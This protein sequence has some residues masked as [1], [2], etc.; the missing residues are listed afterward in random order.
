MPLLVAIAL[1]ASAPLPAHDLR[2]TIRQARAVAHG[3]GER[4]W[5][6]FAHASLPVDLIAADRETLFCAPPLP[7]FAA[8]GR[9]P[10][11]GCTVQAR[12]RRL[13]VDLAGASDLAGRSVIQI[14]LPATLEFTPAEWKLTLIHESFHQYQA[15]LPG[16]RAAVA[17]IGRA[18][19]VGGSGWFLGYAFPYA[20]PRVGAA[21]AAMG[22]AARAFLAARSD[23]ERRIA[24]GD[25]VTA[26]HAARAAAGPQAWQYYE[27]QAGQEGVARWTELTLASG[28]AAAD[29]ALA[30]VAQDRRQGLSTSLDAVDQQ[31]LAVWKR[32]AFYVFGALEAEMLERLHRPWRAAYR[33]HPLALGDQLDRAVAQS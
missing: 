2:A 23:A 20:D 24:V 5:P 12:P 32:S 8:A 13:P 18:L 28:E 31:G 6:G 33:A 15:Q 29:P 11:T 9:D 25:Y 3:P 21:F 7:G 26:R 30:A 16:Y 17:E 4:L 10:V 22:R 19:G 27:F 1:L 14:G